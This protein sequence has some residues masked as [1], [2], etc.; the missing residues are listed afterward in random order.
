V[1]T[2]WD[3]MWEVEVGDFPIIARR[4]SSRVLDVGAEASIRHLPNTSQDGNNRV[5]SPVEV[6]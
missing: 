5:N 6:Q 4:H 1:N 3:R 2:E